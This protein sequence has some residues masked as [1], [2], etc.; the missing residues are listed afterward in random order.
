[1]PFSICAIVG[2]I[3]GTVATSS[4]LYRH[5]SSDAQLLPSR[6]ARRVELDPSARHHHLLVDLVFPNGVHR[7]YSL[8]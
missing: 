2:F 6:P 7:L 3:R 4:L 8:W 1:M 5:H